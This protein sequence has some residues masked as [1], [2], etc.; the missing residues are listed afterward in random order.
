MGTHPIFES[1]FDCLTERD[2]NYMYNSRGG[3]SRSRDS[4]FRLDKRTDES[5]A[6]NNSPRKWTRGTTKSQTQLNQLKISLPH[7]LLSSA[8]TKPKKLKNEKIIHCTFYIHDGKCRNGSGCRFVHDKSR[9]RTCPEYI[10]KGKCQLPKCYLSHVSDPHK[11]E[12]C[13]HFLAGNCRKGADCP[14]PHIK[15][16]PNARICLNFQQGYCK[17]G[18]QCSLKHEKKKKNKKTDELEHLRPFKSAADLEEEAREAELE[19]SLS[20]NGWR[21]RFFI[22]GKKIKIFP[23]RIKMESNI[24]KSHDPPDTSNPLDTDAQV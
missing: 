17:K 22:P 5:S 14:F 12:S 21:S 1:D 9:V 20:I 16:D 4:R 3:L 15:V 10:K 2:R 24:Q 11:M 18:D 19:A 7:Q 8:A 6:Y 13:S 23:N